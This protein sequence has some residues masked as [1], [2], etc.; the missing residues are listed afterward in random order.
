[1]SKKTEEIQMFGNLGT[2]RDENNLFTFQMGSNPLAAI[3]QNDPFMQTSKLTFNQW[4]RVNNYNVIARGVNNTQCEEIEQDI[5]HNRLLPRLINK[6]INMLY[7]TGPAVYR[8]VIQDGKRLKLWEEQK[9]IM[10]WLEH[11]Q[12]N[13][14]EQSYTDF[15]QTV[16]K[17]FY[18]FRDYFVK[19]RMS[20]GASIGKMPV[21]GMEVLENR[22]CRLATTR[23][24]VATTQIYYKDF[25][26]VL[27]GDWLRGAPNYQVYPKFDIKDVLTYQF[28]AISH[29]REKSVGD[30]YGLNET[31]AGTREYI[32]GSNQ[33]AEY[34]NSFLK[35]SLAAKIHIII[36]DA[37]IQSKRKQLTALCEENKRREKEAQ[38]LLTY[39]DIVIG[40]SFRESYLLQVVQAETRKLSEYLSGAPN[41]GKAYVTTS[42]R[43]GQNGQDEERWRI[44]T[45]DL[46]YKEYIESLITYD[47][48][49][50]EVLLSSVG[51]DSSISS[52]SK[53][54]IISKSGSDVYYNY[55]LYLLSLTPDDEKCSEPFNLAIKINFPALYAAGYRIG[56][57]REVPSRQ[58]DVSP[59]NRLNKQQS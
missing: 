23:N 44:E 7:G 16:I 27:V 45:V 50:D 10:D 42:F 12:E 1:M 49:A 24:D 39:G 46:K 26:Q 53:D 32:K 13:G 15:A 6:Q 43:T 57:Y 59:N 20:L 48:R 29:H 51:L 14:M 47:K 36:P 25:R 40:T 17:N 34:I 33:T 37:W 22:S 54:G 21:A 38:P 4:M 52:V 35:N 8:S 55:L 5:K 56:Y 31:H 30:F 18:Y 41:Q 9:V 58:E 11:W 19:W 2:Y 28:A 3:D